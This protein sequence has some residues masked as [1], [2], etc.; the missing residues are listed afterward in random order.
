MGLAVYD[1][2]GVYLLLWC[3]NSP[4][5]NAIESAWPYLKKGNYERAASKTRAEAIRK[6]EAAWN[7]LPQ[8]KIGHG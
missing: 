5:L 1:L 7:E 6:W 2:V 8:E 3:K 4:S